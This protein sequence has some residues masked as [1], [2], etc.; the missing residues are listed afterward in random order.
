MLYARILSFI[1]P[2][3]DWQLR[4][5]HENFISISGP[6]IA[7]GIAIRDDLPLGRAGRQPDAGTQVGTG[8]YDSAAGSSDAK[9]I[10]ELRI[11]IS[12]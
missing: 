3:A 11:E 8:I 5:I 6:D 1:A 10:V 12:P 2:A 7:L 4:Q 9:L